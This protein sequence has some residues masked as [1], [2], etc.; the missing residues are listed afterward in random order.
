[1]HTL[2]VTKDNELH[3]SLVIY[4]EGALERQAFITL[5]GNISTQPKIQIFEGC[6]WDQ[7]LEPLICDRCTI[8]QTQAF[9]RWQCSKTPQP[10]VRDPLAAC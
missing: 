4:G 9:E 7:V 5:I 1:M 8:H 6:Q 10:I 2:P 3:N